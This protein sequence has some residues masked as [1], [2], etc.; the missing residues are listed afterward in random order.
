[1]SAC[2]RSLVFGARARAFVIASHAVFAFW[3][4]TSGKLM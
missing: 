1:M 3:G 2:S 4:G